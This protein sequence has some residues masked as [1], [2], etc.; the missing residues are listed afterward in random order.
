MRRLARDAY[1]LRKIEEWP[2][3]KVRA[4][5]KTTVSLEVLRA[6]VTRFDEDMWEPV[7]NYRAEWVAL[8][9]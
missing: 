6:L 2:W 5:L 4:E 8:K 7:T 1:W 3:E 9:K